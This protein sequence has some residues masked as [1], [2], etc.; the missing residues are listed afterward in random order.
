MVLG[1]ALTSCCLSQLVTESIDLAFLLLMVLFF[2][3]TVPPEPTTPEATGTEYFGVGSLIAGLV[4]H[5]LPRSR[6]LIPLDCSS[7]EMKSVC[8]RRRTPGA[9]MNVNAWWDLWTEVSCR[10]DRFC[11]CGDTHG[12]ALGFHPPS[13]A[14]GIPQA[15]THKSQIMG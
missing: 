8:S 5:N 7:A 15:G 11:L 2:L 9:Q 1:R 13:R 3:L 14:V 6:V 10:T 12:H 4:Q